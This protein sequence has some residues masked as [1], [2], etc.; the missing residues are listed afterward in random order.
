M[1]F[2]VW[3]QPEDQDESSYPTYWQYNFYFDP[4]LDVIEQ[5]ALNEKSC[6]Q[7]LKIQNK[8]EN[9]ELE[10]DC[11]D[12]ISF[13][14]LNAKIA[15]LD[16]K[17]EASKNDNQ[18]PAEPGVGSS[19]LP[20]DLNKMEAI[21][22]HVGSSNP[23]EDLNKKEAIGDHNSKDI[24][25]VKFQ[26]GCRCSARLS[27]TIL[28]SLPQVRYQQQTPAG[29]TLKDKHVLEQETKGLKAVQ[30]NDPSGGMKGQEV[31]R[32]GT[33]RTVEEAWPR[34]LSFKGKEKIKPQ[35][36]KRGGDDYVFK[37]IEGT[38]Q[39][40]GAKR[41]GDFAGISATSH[42]YHFRKRSETS[43]RG[44]VIQGNNN[45]RGVQN[46]LVRSHGGT[47]QE[48]RNI[49]GVPNVAAVSPMPST[50]PPPHKVCLESMTVLQLRAF[51][52]QHKIY[53]VSVTRKAELQQLLRSKLP[54]VYWS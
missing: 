52:N 32:T 12:H 36:T 18:Q 35:K 17:L 16:G 6:R 40:A 20:E 11:E 9:V 27:N 30:N 34:L 26:G 33:D 25:T 24:E 29:T 53:G 41:A 4:R 51:A 1:D 54:P 3:D 2:P 19:N 45:Q 5:E 46:V 48:P 13:A 31:A 23:P 49:S 21:G 42:T 47:S 8:E 43:F 44:P 10:D 38:Q 37:T 7:V 50:L 14:E 28:A 15:N 39:L 22:D